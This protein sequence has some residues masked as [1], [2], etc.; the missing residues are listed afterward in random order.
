MKLLTIFPYLALGILLPV[1]A[2]SQDLPI[3][4]ES[5]SVANIPYEIIVTPT[6]KRSDIRDL[7][8]KLEEDFIDRFNELNTDDD[9]DVV[10]YN[11]TATNSHIRSRTCEPNFLT[12]ARGNNASEAAFALSQAVTAQ[13]LYEIF[14]F[15]PKML[16]KEVHREYDTLRQKLEDI[17]RSDQS[18]RSMALELDKLNSRLKDFGKED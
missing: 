10:C 9:Y 1:L 8:S 16:R 15:T 4:D 3:V 11:F 18:L 12:D 6:F 7:I 14:I 17:T 5:E 13:D 2:Y